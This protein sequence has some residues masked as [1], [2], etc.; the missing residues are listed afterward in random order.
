MH[1]IVCFFAS[2]KNCASASASAIVSV[3][4][5]ASIRRPVW[6]STTVSE[7]GAQLTGGRGGHDPPLFGVRGHNMKC[8]PTFEASVRQGFMSK[9]HNSS[10]NGICWTVVLA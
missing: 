6:A 3:I 8:P 1:N 4:V 7:S 5:S 10:L 2:N 9:R